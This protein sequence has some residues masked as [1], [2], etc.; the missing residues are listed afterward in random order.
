VKV[1]RKIIN[2][3]KGLPKLKHEAEEAATF[4][5][6]RLGKWGMTGEYGRKDMYRAVCKKCGAEVDI[7]ANPKPNE[8]E[9]S[10]EAITIGCNKTAYSKLRYKKEHN[11][12]RK[13]RGVHH[14]S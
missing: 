5:G 14:A 4:R 10:G 3:I 11:A 13:V 7:T 8:I 6:H 12:K 1:S 2:D 9:I